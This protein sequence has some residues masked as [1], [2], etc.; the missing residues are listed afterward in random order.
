MPEF[1]KVALVYL[2]FH[3]EPYLADVIDALK[4]LNY[5]KDR[6]EFVI[7][8]NPHPVHGPSVPFINEHLMPL[9]GNEIPHVTLL[10]QSENLG[11]AGGNNAGVDWALA[12][13]FDYVFFHN[14]D[15]AMAPDSLKA[16]IDVMEA[17]PTIGV[18]QSLMLLDPEK[19]LVNSTGNAFHYLGFGYCDDYRKPISELFLPA[20]KDVAYASGAAFIIRSS[21]LKELGA[22]D[23]D[24]FLYHEDLE[25][26]LRMRITKHRVVC[27]RDS[28]FYHKYEFSRSI[29]KYYWMERNRFGVMLM[30]YKL[31]TFLL[32]LPMLIPLEIGLWFFAAKGGWWKER[33]KVYKYWLQPKNWKLWL[34]KRKKTQS[35]RQIPDREILSITTSKI[36]F[37]EAAQ[38]HW[39]VTKLANPVMDLYFRFIIKP[40]VRW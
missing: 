4:K 39:L 15:G 2:S 12:N 3:C 37:Q 33:V 29:S 31:P 40:L 9:S 26:S 20:V 14:N 18:A 35:I 23:N 17:D 5:P 16:L 25:F 36:L 24:F 21:L 30:F 32:L 11:F 7:V 34:Q 22:W 6:V 27:V 10:A 8:D 13:G 28:V 19:H 1:P 38:Q